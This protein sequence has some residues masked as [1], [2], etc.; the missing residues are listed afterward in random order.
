[1]VASNAVSTAGAVAGEDVNVVASPVAAVPRPSIKVPT[2]GDSPVRF[3]N[4]VT[5]MGKRDD[6]SVR[7]MGVMA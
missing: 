4:S 7:I 1:M 2:A 5:T 3:C 6:M